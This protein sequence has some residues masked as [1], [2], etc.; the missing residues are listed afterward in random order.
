[1]VS[2]L[3]ESAQELRVVVTSRER[4]NLSEETVYTLHGLEYPSGEQS[5]LAAQDSDA[6]GAVNLLMQRAQLLAPNYAP[7]E[8]DLA[9]A[10]RIAQLVEGMPLALLLAASWLPLLS[11]EEIAAEIRANVD[12]LESEAR[13]LPPRQR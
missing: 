13:D 9:A 3:L 8:D 5:S 12:F 2:E 6:Y 7:G 1:F 10:A 11:L 4:L